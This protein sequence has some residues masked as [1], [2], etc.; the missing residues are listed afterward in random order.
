MCIRDSKRRKPCVGRRR[1][2]AFLSGGCRKHRS[3]GG[4]HHLGGWAAIG[5]IA[6]VT[7]AD[8]TALTRLGDGLFNAPDGFVPAEDA[9]LFH[10]YVEK[11]NVDPVREITRMIDVQRSYEMGQSF[12]STE[13][14]R[15]RQVIRVMGGG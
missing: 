7:V 4:W 3:G 10:G 9:T 15:M 6:L 11:S 2:A 8:K 5:Q 14:E 12:L 1:R 13:D